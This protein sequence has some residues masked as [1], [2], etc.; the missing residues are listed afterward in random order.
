MARDGSGI[1]SLPAGTAAVSGALAKS[2]DINSRFSSLETDANTARP[3]IAG[4]TGAATLTG[5]LKGNGTGAFTGATTVPN[6]DVSGLGTMS[7]QAAS[8]VAITGG[9][10][11]VGALGSTS[12][13]PQVTT[14]TGTAYAATFTPA[15]T[16]LTSGL[17][18]SVTLHAN[19]GAAATFAPNGLTAAALRINTAG[20]L[21]APTALQYLT[22]DNLDL[23]YDGTYWV[24]HQGPRAL[25]GD[26]TG[27]L[28]RPSPASVQAQMQAQMV[29]PTNRYDSA[30]HV[31]TLGGTFTLT[32]GLG[33]VP[34]FYQVYLTCVTAWN[35]Y[36]VGEI[37]P[38]N[39]SVNVANA[40]SGGFGIALTSTTARLIMGVSAIEL[41]RFDTGSV[42]AV[43]PAN[44]TVG[45]TLQR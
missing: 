1:F 42:L 22:G 17:R 26:T 8:A 30:G 31:Y 12:Q 14:G 35:G 7:T 6:T 34:K 23:S 18:V 29:D 39:A 25:A 44:W 4:G 27:T 16:A 45:I 32:H 28:A 36:S 20:T 37:V 41:I 2:A 19:I 40:V 21:S 11:V 15:I 24:I 13:T 10:T 3:V 33:S 5:Y 43:T 38:V 9:A